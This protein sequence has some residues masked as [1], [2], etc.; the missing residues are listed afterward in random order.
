MRVFVSISALFMSL[1]AAMSFADE[2]INICDRGQVSDF[3]AKAVG[4]SKC[5]S[6]SKEKLSALKSL[7]LSAK[8]LTEIG[9]GAFEGLSSLKSLNLTR[10]HIDLLPARVFEPL[11]SL[12]DLNAFS[13]GFEHVSDNAFYGFLQYPQTHYF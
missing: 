7:D 5:D 10:N 12:E 8:R 2:M 4:A 11:S 6:V 1:S 13:A 3:I 9:P